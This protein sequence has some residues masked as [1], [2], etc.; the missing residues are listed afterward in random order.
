[1]PEKIKVLLLLATKYRHKLTYPAAEC[2]MRLSGVL[3]KENL[4]TPTKYTLKTAISLYSSA[5]SEHHVCPHCGL[6][7]GVFVETIECNNCHREIDAKTNKKRGNVF[8]YLS[9]AEQIKSLLMNGL[10]S[11]VIQPQQRNKIKTGNYE[12]LPDGKMYKKLV[13]ANCLSFNFFIDGLR[14]RFLVF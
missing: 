11:E 13:A 10:A 7:I 2:I 1:M 14:V 8:L 5:L 9:V 12:D 4:F 6:Y 3:A